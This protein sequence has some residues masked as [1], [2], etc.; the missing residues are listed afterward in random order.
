MEEIALCRAWCDMSKNAEKGNVM[1][2]KGFWDAVI[3]YFIKENGSACGDFNLNNEADE[4][5]E[6]TQEHRPMGRDRS[7]A[8][9]KSSTSSREGSSSFVD[10]VA[11]KFLN[12]KSTK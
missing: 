6:E 12:I 2:A 8:K 4:F 5:E 3:K 7:K 11:D 1:K 10:L 9:K